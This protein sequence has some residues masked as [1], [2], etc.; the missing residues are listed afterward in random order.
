MDSNKQKWVFITGASR[1][2]GKETALYLAQNGY[3][4]V[5]HCSKDI[6]RLDKLKSKIIQLGVE[7][8]TLAFDIRNR[9]ET[10]IKLQRDIEENGVYYG[11]VLNA[12]IAKDNPFP[13]M[14]DSE[15]DDIVT[16]TL[17]GF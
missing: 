7:A 5:L 17:D 16:T 1:G 3:N 15:W 13:A 2:I 11:I 14:E 6:T 4:I 10:S 9:E 8:R 12:G